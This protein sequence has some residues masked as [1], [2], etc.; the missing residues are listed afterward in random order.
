MLFSH[1]VAGNSVLENCNK[2]HGILMKRFGGYDP[3]W[4]L[5]VSSWCFAGNLQYSYKLRATQAI[6]YFTISL[7]MYGEI[8]CR[9]IV[10][11]YSLTFSSEICHPK[12]AE[13]GRK[14][15]PVYPLV[16]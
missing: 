4:C 7:I 8:I 10:N 1:F 16:L 3:L 6:L 9:S 14:N 5:C 15:S 13:I 2:C 12:T 11:K